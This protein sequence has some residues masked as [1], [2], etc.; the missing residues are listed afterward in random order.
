MIFAALAHFFRANR[1]RL[2]AA[3][4]VVLVP[5]FWHRHIAAGDLGS[6]L[7]NAWLAELIRAGKAPGLWI[8]HQSN[9][10]LFDLILSAFSRVL[11]FAA[12]EKLAVSLVVLIFFW[13]AFALVCAA[14]RRTPWF[15]LP[16]LAMVAYGWTFHAGFFNYYLG[17]GLTS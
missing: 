15:L 9:N 3:S 12:T 13:G 11:S 5:C 4:V 16:A 1:F 2:I 7:Y 14:T 8:E 6:H 17:I 10:V